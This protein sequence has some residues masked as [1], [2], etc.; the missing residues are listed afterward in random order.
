MA[1][2]FGLTELVIGTSTQLVYG[3]SIRFFKLSRVPYAKPRA[4]IVNNRMATKAKMVLK[5]LPD[6]ALISLANSILKKSP[7]RYF[8]L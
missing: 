6:R 7:I 2:T 8:G 4:S 5:D 1:P 3:L